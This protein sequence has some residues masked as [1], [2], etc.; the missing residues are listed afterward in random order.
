MYIEGTHQMAICTS[1][2]IPWDRE[3]YTDWRDA[4]AIC[5]IRS[6][7]EVFIDY[8]GNYWNKVLPS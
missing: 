8:G 2:S 6:G 5:E 7:Q 4:D 1:L 3:M